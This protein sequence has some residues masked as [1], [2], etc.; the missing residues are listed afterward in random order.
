[1]G[2]ARRTG[3]VTAESFRSPSCRAMV[4]RGDSSTGFLLSGLVRRFGATRS[5]HAPFCV[6]RRVKLAQAFEVFE[7]IVGAGLEGSIDAR[8]F[9]PEHMDFAVTLSLV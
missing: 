5:P 1:M 9:D 6:I 4:P 7:E 8:R 2:N 3:I